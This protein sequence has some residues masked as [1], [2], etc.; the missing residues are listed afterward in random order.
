MSFYRLFIMD[1]YYGCGTDDFVVPNDQDLLDRP[2]SPENWSKWGIS[3]PED[4]YSSQK[5]FITDKNS[6]EVEF[7][8]KTEV[9][10][11]PSQYDVDQSCDQ[12][13]E[14]SSF[15]PMEDIYLYKSNFWDCDTF[16][17]YACRIIL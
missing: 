6:T 4:Y 17:F 9:E 11:E 7:N 16:W 5:F 14:L 3:T 13:Q 10:F 15:E 1:W 8:F 12:L 2:P